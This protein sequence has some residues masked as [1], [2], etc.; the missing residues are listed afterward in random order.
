[1]CLNS[2][3]AKDIIMAEKIPF[4]N[5][6]VL[7]RLTEKHLNE[8]F[9]LELVASEIQLDRLRLDN[10]AFDRKEGAFVVIEYKNECDPDVLKQA[11]NY[12]DLIQRK[13]EPFIGR[14][15]DQDNVC[16]EKTRIMIVSTEFCDGQREKAEDHFELWKVTLFDDG[17]VTYEN[18]KSDETKTLNIDLNDLKLTEETLLEYKSP[19]MKELYF[20]LKG[21]VLGEYGDV[22]VKYLVD[23]FSFRLNDDIIC[24]I[25]F[26][27]SS[28]NIYL[29]GKNLK[30]S[31]RTTDNST[32]CEVGDY[33]FKYESADDLDYFMDLFGQVYNQR[34]G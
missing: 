24:V 29:N 15:D 27:T 14:L 32:G 25:R 22:S 4:E 7:H 30:N 11:Q 31:E 17:K 18:L 8:L 28:F 2:T 10:L 33:K 19:E 13:P 3:A 5:E 12:Y 23:A 9:D 6:Y 21:R 26:L 16:L 1:M 34:K 20:K